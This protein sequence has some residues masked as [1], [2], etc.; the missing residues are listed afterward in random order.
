MTQV[1][2]TLATSLAKQAD[3]GEQQK[4]QILNL[5]ANLVLRPCGNQWRAFYW[6]VV[7]ELSFIG[8]RFLVVIYGQ[9]LALVEL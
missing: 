4:A 7:Y 2:F 6:L 3:A 5:V 8:N 1:E 9:L